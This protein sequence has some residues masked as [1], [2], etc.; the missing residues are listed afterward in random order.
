MSQRSPVTHTMAIPAMEA[1]VGN[2]IE[3]A[4]N[5]AGYHGHN[6]PADYKFKVYTAGQK[7]RMTPQIKR[8]MKVHGLR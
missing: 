3:R 6:A 2:T 7:R 8:E 4:I 1:M 5:D